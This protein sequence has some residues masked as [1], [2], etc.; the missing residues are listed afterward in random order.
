MRRTVLTGLQAKRNFCKLLDVL[1]LVQ[2]HGFANETEFKAEVDRHLRAF[3][4]GELPQLDVSRWNLV[5]EDFSLN[6]V[7]TPDS[8]RSV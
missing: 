5:R 7:Y 4:K 1:Q 8:I 3:A 2:T 6:T